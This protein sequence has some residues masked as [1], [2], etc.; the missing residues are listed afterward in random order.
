[1]RIHKYFCICRDM[2]VCI[3]L[4]MY[5]FIE[6]YMFNLWEV[7]SCMDGRPYTHIYIYSCLYTCESISKLHCAP[8]APALVPEGLWGIPVV[9]GG[10]SLKQYHSQASW[11]HPSD[12]PPAYSESILIVIQTN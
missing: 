7:H 6:V 5:V 12:V 9:S 8:N 4:F 3:H 10:R 2:G 1:M 11:D